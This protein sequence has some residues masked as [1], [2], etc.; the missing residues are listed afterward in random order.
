MFKY[1]LLN[2]SSINHEVKTIDVKST[3]NYIGLLKEL[4]MSR[5]W[6]LSKYEFCQKELS[7]DTWSVI[8]C[9]QLYKSKG[10]PFE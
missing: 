2:T 7:D 10:K 5:H 1:I 6:D 9:V 3:F 8:C 4:C